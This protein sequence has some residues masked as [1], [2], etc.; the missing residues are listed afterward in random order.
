[1]Q[2]A[3]SSAQ[4]RAFC[5][6]LRERR[7]KAGLKQAEL[8]EILK[9]TQSFVSSYETGGRRLDLV[10]LDQICEA[11]GT[12]LATAVKDFLKHG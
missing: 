5:A 4:Y 3:I 7:E 9:V 6:G 2:K 1:V 8:A 12:D 10:E 11:L